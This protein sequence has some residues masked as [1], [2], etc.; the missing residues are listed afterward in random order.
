MAAKKSTAK[1]QQKK[2]LVAIH[3]HNADCHTVILTSLRVLIEQEGSHWFAQ[4]LEIDYAASGDSLEDVKSNFEN[5][6]IG[7]IHDHIHVHGTLDKFMKAAPP[8]TWEPVLK[9]LLQLSLSMK[10]LFPIGQAKQTDHVGFPFNQIA[11]L[12]PSAAAA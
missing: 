11:Y 10:V 12:E 5:G 4:G 2:K 8:E 6:L 1:Q 3:E 7:T 9:G